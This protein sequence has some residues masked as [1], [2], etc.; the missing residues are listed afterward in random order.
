MEMEARRKRYL[1]KAEEC[2]RLAERTLDPEAKQ[3]LAELARQWRGMAKQIE[4]MNFSGDI[5]DG[6]S[7][8]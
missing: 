5:A 3:Q 6:K 1:A 7:A 4:Q 8:D 2:E